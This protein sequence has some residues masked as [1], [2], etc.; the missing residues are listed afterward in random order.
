MKSVSLSSSSIGSGN[1]WWHE[2]V[3]SHCVQSYVGGIG[4]ESLRYAGT[5]PPKE[6]PAAL[7][8]SV[9]W[10]GSWRPA[11][12]VPSSTGRSPAIHDH[13]VPQW[14]HPMF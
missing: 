4:D 12:G 6:S 9:T 14:R 8:A 13:P 5:N 2:A 1:Q 11:S 7:L 3:D 10:V